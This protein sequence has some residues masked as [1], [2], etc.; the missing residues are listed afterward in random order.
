MLCRVPDLRLIRDLSAK[1][2]PS[3]ARAP[4]RRPR[5]PPRAAVKANAAAGGD[6][7]RTS[8]IPAAN[9]WR[10]RDCA[11]AK[12]S[13][14]RDRPARAAPIG[15]GRCDSASRRQARCSAAPRRRRG[16]ARHRGHGRRR[17]R[18]SAPARPRGGQRQRQ[19]PAPAKAGPRL[20][21]SRRCALRSLDK[22]GCVQC[23]RGAC[24]MPTR[25]EP[26][27]YGAPAQLFHWVIAGADRD[28]I[29]ARANAGASAARRA[30]AGASWRA[31]RAS[32]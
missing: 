31:T 2:R 29:R 17:G 7:R 28:P 16:R 4:D 23:A 9:G 6:F 30:Q 32:E 5:N 10:S 22:L 20:G 3:S 24:L 18:R 12:P 25:T 13:A 27:R 8:P 11:R 26:T 21:V 19:R 1:S 15:R 14:R